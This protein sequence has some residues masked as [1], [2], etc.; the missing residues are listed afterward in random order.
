MMCSQHLINHSHLDDH[1]FSLQMVKWKV[2][3]KKLLQAMW[4]TLQ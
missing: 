1:P 2:N 3:L 4:Q